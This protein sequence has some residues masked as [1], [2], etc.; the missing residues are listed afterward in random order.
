MNDAYG[1]GAS[2]DVFV[3]MACGEMPPHP[4]GWD[5]WW[6]RHREQVGKA[7]FEAQDS[8]KRTIEFRFLKV[9]EANGLLP[10][11]TAGVVPVGVLRDLRAIVLTETK[12]DEGKA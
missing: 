3:N 8:A 5:E 2:A 7:M 6:N 1:V 11:P 9:L 12:T 10:I 4:P